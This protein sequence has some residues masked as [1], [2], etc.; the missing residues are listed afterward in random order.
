MNIQQQ[1]DSVIKFHQIPQVE[2]LQEPK[3][4]PERQVQHEEEVSSAEKTALRGVSGTVNWLATQTRPDLSF[5]V[6]DLS[7][8]VKT[9]KVADLQRAARVVRKAQATRV[10]L[11][12]PNLDLYQS[13]L[14]VY[15]DASYGNLPDGSSQGGYI[16]FLRD[17][18]GKCAPLAWSSAKIKRI[19]RSTLAA[20]CMALQDGADAAVLLSS[21]I[22][23]AL[24]GGSE[25]VNVVCF[26]DSRGLYRALYSTKTVQDERLRIDIARLKQMMEEQEVSQICWIDGSQQLA[27]CLTKRTT[28]RN[29][30]LDVLKMGVL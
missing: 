18:S 6:C 12:F 19:A 28:S 4:T 14:V 5:D 11:K 10:C 8:S 29:V 24:Y 16:V 30:L 3:I 22:S 27:D 7:C 13:S 25:P 1:P 26:T 23:E 2:Q 15:S 17:K 9:A 21:L 20:E